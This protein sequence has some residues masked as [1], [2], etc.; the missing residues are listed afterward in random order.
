MTLCNPTDCSPPGSPAHERVLP[1]PSSGNLPN[2]GIKPRPPALQADSFPLSHLGSPT[3]TK[4]QRAKSNRNLFLPVLEAGSLRIWLQWIQCLVSTHFPIK[5]SLPT[6]TS[7]DQRNKTC[8]QCLFYK[9]THP[10]PEDSNLIRGP[11]SKHHL[12]GNWV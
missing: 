3:I 11:T 1:C 10:T 12:T 8:L 9:D 4:Y 2:P 6:I 5:S 7:H